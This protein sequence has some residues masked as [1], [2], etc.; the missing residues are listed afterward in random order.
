MN[1]KHSMLAALLALVI[2]FMVAS[3]EQP[4]SPLVNKVRQ[5]TEQYRDI[6]AAIAQGFVPA[7]TCVSGPDMGAMG[8]HYVLPA[9]VN[10]G[11]LNA[12][13]PEVL[14]YEPMANGALR[15]E[16]FEYVVLASIW[17]AHNAASAVPSLEG[18]LLN[19]QD[20]PNRYGLPPHYYLH[21]WAWEDNPKGTFADWNTH[22]TCT[23]QPAS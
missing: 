14:I 17:S 2:P 7:T 6:N 3:A 23:Q 1:T 5:A 22:V 18:N 8:V 4:Y 16:G 20:A 19:F 15:Q 10:D 21:L 9:R 13:Q 11:L 12:E